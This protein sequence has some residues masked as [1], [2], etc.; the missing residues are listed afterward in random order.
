ML[1]EQDL[2]VCLRRAVLGVT[3]VIDGQLDDVRLVGVDPVTSPNGISAGGGNAQA[4]A[5][6]VFAEAGALIANAE[7][8]QNLGDAA[9]VSINAAIAPGVAIGDIGT[10]QRLLER[11]DI[12]RLIVLPQQPIDQ[13]ALETIAPQLRLQR[14]D[15][16]ADIAQL[17]D[18]FHL[19]LPAFGLLSFAVG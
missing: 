19:N 2:F 14:A 6:M 7:T 10:V 4:P 8:A 15:Q 5:A 18:S 1:I 9:K 3:P 13:P 11:D 12:S 17:T 16:T